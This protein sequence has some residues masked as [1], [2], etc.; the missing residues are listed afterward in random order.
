ML[1]KPSERALTIVFKSVK[2]TAQLDRKDPDSQ[3]GVSVMDDTGRQERSQGWDQH[4]D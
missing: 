2:Y 1:L 4:A 3:G